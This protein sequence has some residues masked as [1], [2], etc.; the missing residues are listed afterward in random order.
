MDLSHQIALEQGQVPS[1]LMMSNVLEQ[2]V[3]P[4]LPTTGPWT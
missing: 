1:G 3:Y 2:K 4:E